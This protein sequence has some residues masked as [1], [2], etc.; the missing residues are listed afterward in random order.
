MTPNWSLL[1]EITNEYDH[2]HE[3]SINLGLDR[4]CFCWRFLIGNRCSFQAQFYFCTP[5]QMRLIRLIFL[6]KHIFWLLINNIVTLIQWVSNIHWQSPIISLWDLATTLMIFGLVTFTKI[7]LHSSSSS[8]IRSVTHQV[9]RHLIFC[10][11]GGQI[12]RQHVIVRCRSTCIVG[13]L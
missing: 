10:G 13:I 3:L 5:R 11:R 1:W 2:K 8:I 4:N 7:K 6:I 12:R 9:I